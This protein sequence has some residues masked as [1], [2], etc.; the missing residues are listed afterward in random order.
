[1]P[2]RICYSTGHA[3]G[4]RVQAGMK[5]HLGIPLK[6]RGHVV[7]TLTLCKY[8]DNER[9][10]CVPDPCASSV[11]VTST[12]MFPSARG[13]LF[14]LF[15]IPFHF[16]HISPLHLSVV[17]GSLVSRNCNHVQQHFLACCPRLELFSMNV[18]HPKV[19]QFY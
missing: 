1:M 13:F 16:A 3:E 10:K 2:R 18:K 8:Q 12:G 14:T 7:P 9:R 4:F 5:N 11:R 6:R 17:N 19:H 15:I